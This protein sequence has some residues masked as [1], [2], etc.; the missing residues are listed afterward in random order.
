MNLNGTVLADDII[1]FN[2]HCICDVT[3]CASGIALKLLT[4]F[5]VNGNLLLSDLLQTAHFILLMPAN[6]LEEQLPVFEPFQAEQQFLMTALFQP[7]G[8]QL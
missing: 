7:R 2:I 4:A 1:Y 5:R 6:F 8:H 3:S